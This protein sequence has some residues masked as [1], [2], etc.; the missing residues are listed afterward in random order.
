MTTPVQMLLRQFTAAE[1]QAMFLAGEVGRVGV[2]AF[3]I[4]V[5][6]DETTSV[7]DRARSLHP[8]CTPGRTIG[9]TA[10]AWV[11]A[12]GS[13]P[14][15]VEIMRHSS[16][17]LRESHIEFVRAVLIESDI[18][19]IAGCRLTTPVATLRM[20][21]ARGEQVFSARMATMLGARSAAELQACSTRNA[22]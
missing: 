20:L 10:A 22:S 12:G 9:G 15:R 18:T 19:E 17:T 6:L 7:A 4:Y 11:W 3:P 14:E 2:P 13:A 8:L 21:R 1:L 16:R 5:P